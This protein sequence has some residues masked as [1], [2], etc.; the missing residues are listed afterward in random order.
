[1][2]H[3]ALVTRS[4]SRF[5]RSQGLPGSGF[6]AF[7]GGAVFAAAVVAV[8]WVVVPLLLPSQELLIR[9]I[10]VP[11]LL[12][13]LV[14]S[15]ALTL[16]SMRRGVLLQSWARHRGLGY[17]HQHRA[18][19]NSP[20]SGAPFPRTG[21][22]VVRH[23]LIGDG[24][25][26][27]RFRSVPDGRGYH[28]AGLVDSFTFVRF[29]LPTFVP[30]LVVTGNRRS[31]LRAAGLA[32]GSGRKLGGSIEFDSVFTLHCPA[33]YERDALYIFTP[34]LL[35]LLI[36]HAPGCD[37]ELVD[38]SAYLYFSR[39][40]K[41]W[42]E[43]VADDLLAVVDRL[44]RKLERQTRSYADGTREREV[45]A[46]ASSSSAAAASGVSLGGLR[47]ASKTSTR[48]RVVALAVWMP[49]IAVIAVVVAQ[50][51]GWISL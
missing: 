28:S 10:G 31:V 12:A 36:D 45:G 47:L 24:F 6:L 18:T 42:N 19:R 30:H 2:E 20:W 50:A 46:G 51:L 39:E 4:W 32:I 33:D 25:E 37:L 8:A 44:R 17:V 48:G 5:I 43:R 23:H 34:D 29:D 26:S 11:L 49:G 38:N 3:P 1:M 13:G 21:G 7:V 15:L 35:A 16:R 41:I 27:A 14:L 40:P 9:A 22:Y